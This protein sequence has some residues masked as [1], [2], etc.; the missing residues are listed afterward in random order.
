MRRVLFRRSRDPFI[1]T[2]DA[3][4]TDDTVEEVRITVRAEKDRDSGR[5][6]SRT[7]SPVLKVA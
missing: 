1:P 7:S 2:A 5:L 4:T 3:P 6:N